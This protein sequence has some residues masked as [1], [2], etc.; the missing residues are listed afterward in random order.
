MNPGDSFQI[1]RFD[2]ASSSFRPLPVPNTPESI[3]DGLSYL[4]GFSGAGG[5]NMIEGIKAALDFPRDP[6]R[7][8]IGRLLSARDERPDLAAVEEATALGLKHKLVTPFTSFVAVER[9]LRP[10]IELPMTSVL[11]PHEMPEGVSER[12]IFGEGATVSI[13]RLKPGDPVL[14]VDAPRDALAVIADFPF[15]A[16]RLCSWDADREKW[17]CRFL[18]PRSVADGRYE[19]KVTCVNA[20]GTRTFMEAEYAVDSRAPQF[21]VTARRAGGGTLVTARPRRFVLEERRGPGGRMSV[22]HD[23]KRVRLLLAGERAVALRLEKRPGEFVWS[24]RVA[25]R[26]RAVLEAV[27]YA[28]NAWREEVTLP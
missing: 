6:A 17:A 10:G 1:I 22:T 4:N 14:S 15:G 2:Q 21:E 27:D 28:G 12:G 24:A 7:R 3:R 25:A 11:I 5:T 26:G 19:I 9:E 20:D 18:V 16:R 13:P 8:R 23:A